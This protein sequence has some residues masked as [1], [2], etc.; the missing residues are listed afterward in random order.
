LGQTGGGVFLGIILTL[1]RAR[2][3]CSQS[4]FIA[5]DG[6]VISPMWGLGVVENRLCQNQIRPLR[7][8]Q[9]ST[10]RRDFIRGKTSR[11]A[12][13]REAVGTCASS[14]TLSPLTH[15]R[16]KRGLDFAERSPHRYRLLFNDPEIGQERG[17]LETE[18]LA[19]FE[20]VVRLIKAAQKEGELKKGDASQFTALLYGS[21]HGLADLRLSGRA[22][23]A[24]GMEDIG[25]LPLILLDLLKK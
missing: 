18:A 6:L 25:V 22:R 14:L 4:P 15:D 8:K 17:E 20:A 1:N 13:V 23:S 5:E 16:R 21:L 10:R 24:K 3:F 12:R 9:A 7:S 11:V 2:V 19:T